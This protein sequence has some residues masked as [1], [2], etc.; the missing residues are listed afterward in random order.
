MR[1]ILRMA[2]ASALAL[3]LLAGV[4]ACEPEDVLDVALPTAKAAAVKL[5]ATA[6][7]GD[8][9]SRERLLAGLEGYCEVDE[10]DRL[11]LRHAL[12]HAGQP[13]VTVDCAVVAALVGRSA[14][15][16]PPPG[17][18]PLDAP[19]RTATDPPAPRWERMVAALRP[20]PHRR[21]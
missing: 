19:E 5:A 6:A 1:S 8:T 10:A 18:P 4:T 14:S 12:E 7:A 11:A 13:A 20:E 17:S 15:A 3:F 21:E 2:G 9:K 16:E